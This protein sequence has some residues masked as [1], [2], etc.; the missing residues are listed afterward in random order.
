MM[1]AL[2][3]LRINATKC[4]RFNNYERFFIAS[5]AVMAHLVVHRE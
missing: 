5:E 3:L 2:N 1:N 4:L